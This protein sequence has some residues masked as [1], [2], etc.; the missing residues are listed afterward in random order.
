MV[1]FMSSP[2]E[3]DTTNICYKYGSAMTP[4]YTVLAIWVGSIVLVAIMKVKVDEDEIKR[5]LSQIRPILGDISFS[6]CWDRSG[7]YHASCT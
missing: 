5:T 6:S 1:N 3:L 7:D 2:M 4:F